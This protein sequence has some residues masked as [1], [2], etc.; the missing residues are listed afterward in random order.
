MLALGA[1]LSVQANDT[2][3]LRALLAAYPRFVSEGNR[4]GFE[5]L[6]LDKD[7]PFRGVYDNRATSSQQLRDYTHFREAVFDSGHRYRQTFSHVVVEMHGAIAQASLDFETID[8]AHP[9]E[10]TRG[11]KILQFVRGEGGWR[12]ASELWGAAR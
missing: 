8:L 6:L 2:K 4:Q 7:I 9:S 11:W 5:G 3:E 10:P 12:I 1:P